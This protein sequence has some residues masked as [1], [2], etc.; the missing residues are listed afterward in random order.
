MSIERRATRMAVAGIGAI[1]AFAVT[2]CTENPPNISACVIHA[3]A[4]GMNDPNPSVE[5]RIHKR[6]EMTEDGTRHTIYEVQAGRDQKY[7]QEGGTV[8]FTPDGDLKF[9][10]DA[11]YDVTLRDVTTDCIAVHATVQE[12]SQPKP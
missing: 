10:S 1:S 4:A 7:L 8:K 11:D 12:A 9:N 5:G 3:K 2:S 6:T